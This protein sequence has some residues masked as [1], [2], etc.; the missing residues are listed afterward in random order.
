M[1]ECNRWT[2]DDQTAMPRQNY[3]WD[4]SAASTAWMGRATGWGWVENDVAYEFVRLGI[5]TPQLGLLDGTGAGIVRWLALQ[6]YAAANQRARYDLVADIAE[7]CPVL[8]G[9]SRWYHWS[10]VRGVDDEENLLLANPAP[11]WA[12]IWQTMTEDQFNM[13]GDF[14]AVFPVA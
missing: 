5:A 13:F 8:I 7:T 4:C 3:D 1:P 2:Y 14:Y 11:G 10:G 12:G 6:P 9:S